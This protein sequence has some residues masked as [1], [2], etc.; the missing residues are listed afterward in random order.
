M[1]DEWVKWA[2]EQASRAEEHI[3]EARRLAQKN[4]P[5]ALA[6]LIDHLDRAKIAVFEIHV[7]TGNA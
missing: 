1:A 2:R 4:D 7:G 3:N 6:A 5:D